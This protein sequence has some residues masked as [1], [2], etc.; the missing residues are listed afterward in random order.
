MKEYLFWN[1]ELYI[2]R[3]P[4]GTL[5]LTTK[6][7]LPGETITKR[8]VQKYRINDTAAEI[9]QLIDGTRTYD[10]VLKTLVEKYNDDLKAVE[11]KLHV[12]L[13]KLKVSYN[14]F[15]EKQSEL[16]KQ[17]IVTENRIT[18]YPEVAS[19][20]ITNKCNIRCIHCYGNYG[21]L[22]SRI[23]TIKEVKG[24]LSDLKNVGVRIIEITG[25]EATTHPN[26]E[27]I[28]L[29]A[30]NLNFEQISLLT[31]GVKISEKLMEILIKNRNKIYMQIDLH[32]LNDEYLTW[33]TKVPN[34][35]EPVKSNI[36]RLSKAN[37]RMRVATILTKRNINELESIADWVHNLGI[38]RFGVSP[39]VS[40]GRATNHD[41]N[42]YINE[43]DVI[44]ANEI[45]KKIN[46]KY[47]NFLT[48][49]D[50]EQSQS[51]NC[52]CITSHIVI[53]S[54]GD[55][56]ICTMD[57]LEYFDSSIGNVLKEKIN[58]IYDRNS[59]YIL[60]FFNTPA[61]KTFFN[62]CKDC[63]NIGFCNSCML[64]GLIKAKEVGK[65]CLWYSNY[66]EA[67]VKRKLKLDAKL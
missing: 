39:V 29:Y 27:E 9:I 54:N 21:D 20:E 31:N 14:I 5:V 35:L 30:I 18:M 44:E 22:E 63:L 1:E 36:E 67:H 42:L 32:S 40:L 51:M 12:L 10:E 48:L 61:P 16:K 25:G 28:L 24:L 66:V 26:I 55:I 33:F 38:K 45:L 50:G 59:E 34:T 7:F 58:D 53:S 60:D 37:V 19:V 41:S 65:Q 47:E 57:T 62:E 3:Y 13:E 49:I 15:I 64:R 17:N 56:K 4:N 23:M 11:D 8:D 46:D 43:K 6:R 52:G 2:S